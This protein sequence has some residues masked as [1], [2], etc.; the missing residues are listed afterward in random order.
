MITPQKKEAFPLSWPEDWPRTRPQDRRPMASWKRTANQYR[1]ALATE[2]A[3]MQS[4]SAVISTN[5]PLNLRGAMTPGVEPL[6]VG[7]AVYFARK[8]KE[9]FSW[10]DALELHDP[11]PTE[12]QV[13]EAY[14]RLAQQYHP[15]KGGDIAMFQSITKH[16]DNALRWINRRTNQQFDYV[17]AADQFLEVRLN[18][19]AI[20]NTLKAIRQIE[21][22]GTSSL[23]ERAFKGFAALPAHVEAE[24]VG[25]R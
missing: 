14:R 20:V 17:I 23:L 13:T 3:R 12:Q 2:L 25:A 19:A 1:E 21:R 22:C 15:D 5:V 9:D 4:P 18:L 24:T 8:L 11:A 10:Q 7:V 6:D 16:R